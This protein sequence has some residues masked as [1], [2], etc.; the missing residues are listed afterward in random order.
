MWSTNGIFL[1]LHNVFKHSLVSLALSLYRSLRAMM[2]D[3]IMAFFSVL[4]DVPRATISQAI[5]FGVT[6]HHKSSVLQWSTMTS[7][8]SN[9]DENSGVVNK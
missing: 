4:T 2:S 7:G 8:N 5:I 1:L 6:V 9:D 3:I